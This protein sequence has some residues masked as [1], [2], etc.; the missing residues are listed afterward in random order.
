MPPEA[1][2]A[3]HKY[4][5]DRASYKAVCEDVL[6]CSWGD[7]VEVSRKLTRSVQASLEA[8]IEE[9]VATFCDVFVEDIIGKELST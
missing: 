3:I 2:E 5:E 4:R 1:V 8:E 6:R 9:E 7:Q